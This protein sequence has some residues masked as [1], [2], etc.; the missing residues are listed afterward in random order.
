VVPTSS[1]PVNESGSA[2]RKQ[3]VRQTRSKRGKK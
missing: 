1:R 3:P 2:G